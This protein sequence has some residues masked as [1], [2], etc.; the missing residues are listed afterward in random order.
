MK[1]SLFNMIFVMLIVCGLSAWA[2]GYVYQ[3]TKE[4]I[5]IAKNQK[6]VDAIAKIVG[7]FDNNPFDEKTNINAG[8]SKLEMFP[9]RQN[10]N[11]SAVAI[12]TYSKN[13]FSGK[14]ELIIGISM[15]GTILGYKVIEHAE[16]QGLGSKITEK[17]FSDQFVGLNTK[18]SEYKLS[19]DGGEV[20][21]LTGATI[22]S[23]AVVDAIGKAAKAYNKFS[24]GASGDE[25]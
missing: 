4:P 15:D 9:A 25:N 7:E 20:D 19:N 6:T 11:I 1:S 12:K 16:T 2:L 13:G 3:I 14:I 22:S 18:S 8:K 21:A 23:K 17:K 5:D 24:A 10:G